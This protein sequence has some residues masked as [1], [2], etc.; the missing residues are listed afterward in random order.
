[1]YRRRNFRTLQTHEEKP[2]QVKKEVINK[3]EDKKEEPVIKAVTCPREEIKSTEVGKAPILNVLRNIE[4][5]K[6]TSDHSVPFDIA[7]DILLSEGYLDANFERYNKKTLQSTEPITTEANEWHSL[8]KNTT[9]YERKQFVAGDI[10]F[11][12]DAYKT[13]AFIITDVYTKGDEASGER[14]SYLDYKN[15]LG[16]R[17]TNPETRIM[18]TCTDCCG[19]CYMFKKGITLENIT[20]F[21]SIDTT[22]GKLRYLEPSNASVYDSTATIPP[23]WTSGRKV[24]PKQVKGSRFD[25]TFNGEPDSKILPTEE[26]DAAKQNQFNLNGIITVQGWLIYLKSTE[27]IQ[28]NSTVEAVKDSIIGDVVRTDVI[29]I[30]VKGNTI[31]SIDSVFEIP[32]PDT[33]EDATSWPLSY[34]GNCTAFASEPLNSDGYQSNYG[35]TQGR[36]TYQVSESAIYSFKKYSTPEPTTP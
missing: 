16:E 31:L 17:K 4:Y 3:K 29:E 15:P 35:D 25:S 24:I 28:P 13:F 8:Y 18:Q 34:R 30:G 10:I 19:R 33:S 6:Q 14:S 5:F 32:Y 21:L 20:Q 36:N 1:M 2:V 26:T 23:N 9:N 7:I 22:T 12:K 11:T 27:E